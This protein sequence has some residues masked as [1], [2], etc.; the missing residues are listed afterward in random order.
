VLLLA[1]TLVSLLLG[2]TLFLNN[3]IPCSSA[4]NYATCLNV[5]VIWGT[6]QFFLAAGALGEAFLLGLG[7][8]LVGL[9]RS[10]PEDP[11]AL[12]LGT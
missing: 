6:L 7:I 2:S 10:I 3:V 11:E 8:F 9:R 4:Q 1:Y 12:W 5:Q